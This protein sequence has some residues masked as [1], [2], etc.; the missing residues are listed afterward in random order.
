M[1]TVR[2]DAALVA[3]HFGV[4][5]VLV[6]AGAPAPYEHLATLLLRHVGPFVNVAV[7]RALVGRA[8]TSL[9]LARLAAAA[10]ARRFDRAACDY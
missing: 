7:A 6:V 2:A 5:A 10:F 1:F 4:E 3:L 9:R 8:G